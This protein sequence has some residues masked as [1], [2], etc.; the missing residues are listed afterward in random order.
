MSST[1]GQDSI[2]V[3]DPALLS[4]LVCPETMS[5]LEYNKANSELISRQAG[6]AF[7]V[8]DGVPVLLADQARAL[9]PDD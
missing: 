5:P 4:L 8:I 6:L 9:N 2:R 7:P 1:N 3:L